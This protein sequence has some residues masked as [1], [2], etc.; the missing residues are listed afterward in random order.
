M[1]K[2]ETAQVLAILKAAYPHFYRNASKQDA[3]TAV[4]LW[5]ELFADDPEDVVAAAV[6]ALIATDEKGYPPHIGAVK[7]KMRQLTRKPSMTDAEAWAKVMQAIRQS[8]YSCKSEF[9]KLPED[10]QDLVGSPSQLREW[11]M[12]DTQTLQSVVSS[13]FQR[14]Y[15]ERK[16]KAEECAAL[17]EDIKRL[18]A[19]VIHK[20]ALETSDRKGIESH[21]L[22]RDRP[23]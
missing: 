5:H 2:S 14:S 4:N 20:I 19:A 3:L 18:S 1:T 9:D 22:H 12:M 8:G 16:R 13:N 15:R 11:G 23:W 21:D 10:L 6:K 7:A 17:P